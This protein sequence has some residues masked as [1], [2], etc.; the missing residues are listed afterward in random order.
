MS[1][2]ALCCCDRAFPRAASDMLI[3][4]TASTTNA[5]N[6]HGAIRQRHSELNRLSPSGVGHQ[7]LSFLS[8]AQERTPRRNP[9]IFNSITNE[10]NRVIGFAGVM[11]LVAWAW[12]SYSGAHL[13]STLAWGVCFLI[14][15]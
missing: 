15:V 10:I 8:P 3:A 11:Y 6:T 1:A 7:R 5:A 4:I 12:T 13:G 14:A 2:K 9:L